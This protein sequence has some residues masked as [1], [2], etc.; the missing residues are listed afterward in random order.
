VGRGTQERQEKGAYIG[1]EVEGDLGILDTKH[2]VVKL[3]W[4]SPFDEYSP[5][6]Y[7]PLLTLKVAVSCVRGMLIRAGVLKGSIGCVRERSK[8]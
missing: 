1:V 4:G 7:R 3:E 8:D 6:R 2:C 5:W